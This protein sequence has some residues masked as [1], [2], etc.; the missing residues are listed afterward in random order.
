MLKEPTGFSNEATYRSYDYNIYVSI[1][2]GLPAI[3]A[4]GRLRKDQH[5]LPMF[6]R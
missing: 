6:F 5:V 1:F 4:L 2:L 3:P